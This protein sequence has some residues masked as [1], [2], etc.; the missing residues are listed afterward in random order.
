L[1]HGRQPHKSFTG[2]DSSYEPPEVPQIRIDTTQMS[3][4]EPADLIV[5]RLIP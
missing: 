5:A 4:E 1:H 2:I 3:A